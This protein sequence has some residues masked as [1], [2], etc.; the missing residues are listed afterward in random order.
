MT[1][2]TV[3]MRTVAP[4]QASGSRPD[5]D[6][7]VWHLG[8]DQVESNTGRVLTREIKRAGDAGTST[9]VFDEGNVLY[10][11][12]RPYL[13]KV[14]CP[15][16]VGISTTEMVP[17]RPVPDAIARRF[18]MY[19]L[20]SDRF[21]RFASQ[22]V[23]GVKM[24]RVIMD[25]F[26]THKVPMPGLSEQRQIVDILD[27]AD[28]LQQ[29]RL[30]ADKKA[31]SVLPALFYKLF[32][33]PSTNPKGWE[34]K[35]LGD[36]TIGKPQ[37][38]ANA[39]AVEWS[40]GKPRYVRITDITD[41]GRLLGSGAV[42]L[43]LDDAGPYILKRG[44]LLFARSG[45]TVGKTYLYHPHDGRCAYAGYLIRFKPDMK[46]ALP[47]FLFALTQTDYYRAWV[48]ARKRVAGQPNINGK[49]YASLRIPCPPLPLQ[50]KFE[51]MAEQIA[52]LRDARDATGRQ[53]G[54]LFDV[55]LYRAFAGSLTSGWRDRHKDQLE[56]EVQQQLAA[57]EEAKAAKPKRGR[58]K[59]N[60]K[61]E[62]SSEESRHAG[63]DM[64]NKAALVTYITVKCHDP[65][66]PQSLGR[67]KLA[68][69]FYLVQRRAE[70]SLTDQFTRRAAGPLDDAIHK[71]LNLAKK[72]GWLALPKP[73]GKLKPVV[74]GDDPQPAIDHVQQR[75][76]DALAVM[77]GVLDTMKGWGWE[78]LERW[79]TVE[80]AAQQL[81]ADG[82]PATLDG[83][84]AVIAA[85]PK[86]RAKLKRDAFGDS[87]IQ[88]TLAGLR[89]H[90]Y[91]PAT[92]GTSGGSE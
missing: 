4:A 66:R 14:I 13:N 33:D 61:D 29:Q 87:Q 32:G 45:N 80:N 63:R 90:G 54:H 12:L 84:K 26:W 86:W 16:E 62:R 92:S 75:W 2:T 78:A 31:R 83:V 22:A 57:L 21:L 10:S 15:D 1:W 58:K 36:V 60:A 56:A 41:D 88:S 9:F 25:K 55:L 3:A 74:P 28:S 64:F 5:A 42:T 77:D 20:R 69:L 68:K 65:K 18:L 38:G 27:K 19:Y 91:L 76:A 37:Y 50:K 72:Q 44:D 34:V 82:K 70:I 49:E 48:D 59:A 53:L 17:L 7:E 40:E 46:Q 52:D 47:W 39:S 89:R 67:T 51:H 73:K 30:C 11:K 8:L 6:A 23:A 35:T 81:A 71:F 85:E 43:D 79:A 24:P